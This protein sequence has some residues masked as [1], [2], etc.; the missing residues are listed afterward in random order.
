MPPSRLRRAVRLLCAPSSPRDN[1]I[2]T[3]D[4][5]SIDAAVT[6]TGARDRLCKRM[7]A[8]AL[9]SAVAVSFAACGSGTSHSASLPQLAPESGGPAAQYTGALAGATLRLTIPGPA[10]SAFKRRPAYVSS[11]TKSVKFTVNTASN[12][13]AGQISAYNAS[14]SLNHVDTGTLPNAT[15]PASG[16]DFV[17]T[18]AIK[19]PPGTD[20]ITFAAY[21]NTGGA[22]NVL[23][24][25]VNT[26][27]VVA[28]AAN[29]FSIVLD[30]NLATPSGSLVV[31]GSGACQN[32]AVGSTYGSVGT[33]PVTF[34]VAYTDAA[35]KTIPSGVVGQ[36][37]LQIQ[38]NTATYQSASGT[39]NATGGTVAFSI[40]QAAQ[41]YTLAPSTVPISNAS[42]NVRAIAPNSTGSSDG[43]TYTAASSTKAFT[44]AAGVAPPAHNF[45]AAVEQFGVGSGAVDFF[46]VALGGS[47]G[48]D[49]ISAYSPATLATTN[50]NGGSGPPDVDNP[51]NLAFDSSG[52]LLIGNGGTTTGTP[53]DN[54]N[55]ACVPVGAIATG[56]N[57]STTV[58]TNVDDPVGI[59]YDSRDGSVALA[60]NP[61]SAPVQ[62]AE[63]L[64]TGNYTAAAP[65]R[66]LTVSGMGSFGL[67]N[68]PT[69]AAGS[70]AI[71]LTT[72]VENDPAHNT[73]SA[74]IAIVTPTSATTSTETDILP[75]GAGTNCTAN[76]CA[77]PATYGI[78]IPHQ[79]AWDP[80]NSQLVIA[81][82][83][84]FHKLLTFYNLAGTQLFAVNTALRNDKVATSP[85]GH[86]AVSG[87]G[88]FG[89]PQ[90]KVYDNTAA[91]NA[92]GGPIPFNGTTTS[93][94][95]TY[96]YG[97]GAVVN[98]LSWLSNTKLL[99][100]LQSYNGAT[101]TAQNGLYV[102]DISA[103]AVPTGFDDVS[104]SAFAAAP[105]Q[106]G[107][108]HINNKP[109]GTAFKQ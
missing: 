45:L 77:I 68:L 34:T 58:T 6:G 74:K 84:A 51:L 55:L 88:A 29:S 50:S 32:G 99:I 79:I 97:S 108:V 15:C 37:K 78:D 27:S 83:S 101:A 4:F 105:K 26:Y 9:A 20:N 86:V 63:F 104:C 49:T 91:R 62:L 98:S 70:Y 18:I 85:D 10:S 3:L 43:L 106:T 16:A 96:I 82:N 102:F 48:A 66:N 2:T 38:D 59:A 81:N 57:S 100:A 21:D 35:G 67:T 12:L 42:I 73:G 54:G 103:T 89:Y 31:N 80:M 41:S 13:T 72:G 39:I 23:S 47:G 94:G 52:D 7:L 75:S 24:Q 30:A 71:A 46:T 65:G 22:G 56:Q 40:N 90:V 53:V 76:P 93:C 14:A 17:C 60:N 11:A 64:L 28:A 25:Q 109:L 92:V 1:A 8:A 107:F 69:Q 36:P 87:T 19:L 5:F 95:S 44:F 61:T 33:S